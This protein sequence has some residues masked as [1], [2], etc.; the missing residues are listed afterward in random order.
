MIKTIKYS[1]LTDEQKRKWIEFKDNYFGARNYL[2]DF[3]Y[4]NLKAGSNFNNRKV[5]V[6]EMNDCYYEFLKCAGLV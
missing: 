4:K 6:D 1:D 2:D 5:T 3:M